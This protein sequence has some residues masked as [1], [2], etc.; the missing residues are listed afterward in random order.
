MK[1][2]RRA[3]FPLSVILLLIIWEIWTKYSSVPTYKLP[4]PSR[5]FGQ[6]TATYLLLGHHLLVTVIEVLLGMIVG[7]SLALSTALLFFWIP[8]LK[9]AFYPCARMLNSMPIPAI[10]SLIVIWAGVGIESKLITATICAYFPVVCYAYLGLVS[11]DP[12]REKL[13]TSLNAS[14]WQKLWYLEL[15]SAA[16]QILAA[17]ETAVTIVI[18]GVFVGEMF[19]SNEG[20]GFYVLNLKY[21]MDT[22]KVMLATFTTMIL[23]WTLG[24]IV[25][26]LKHRL[27][28][29][30]QSMQRR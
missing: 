12:L 23:G 26:L 21:R 27:I 2:W 5:I 15:P 9:D 4:S 17:L 29:W 6:S 8:F 22:P 1:I 30:H 25:V 24:E 16:P 10:A 28:P 7:I 19:G 18:V 13:L 3:L 11:V 20:L 14:R